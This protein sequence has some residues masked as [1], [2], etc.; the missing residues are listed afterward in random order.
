MAFDGIAARCIVWELSGLIRGGK[1]LK[2]FQPEEDEI[3]L[4]IRRNTANYRLLISAN[5]QN[6]RIGIT[7]ISKE[8]PMTAPNFCMALRKHLQG[9]VI[10]DI[11]QKDCDRI[12]TITFDTFNEMGDPVVKKLVAEI[13]GRYSNIILL[14]GGDTIIDSIRHVDSRLS[15]YREV[16]PA[17]PY[18]PPPPQDKILPWDSGA[19]EKVLAALGDDAFRDRNVG[20]LLADTISGFSKPLCVSVC[21]RAGVPYDQKAGETAGSPQTAE[22]LCAALSEVFERISE[23]RYSPGII[24]EGEGAPADFHPLTEFFAE[25]SKRYNTLS[26][27]MD[28]FFRE[29]D[30]A[31]HRKNVS[32]GLLKVINGAIDKNA[33]KLAALRLDVENAADFD[34]QKLFGDIL[35]GNLYR[36]SGGEKEIVCDDYSSGCPVKVTIPLDP[37]QSPGKNLQ[38]YYK[39]YK[40][41]KSK[42]E[43]A[44]VHIE[45]TERELA[46]L[47]SVRFSLENCVSMEDIAQI[48]NE[49]QGGGYVK[50]VSEKMKKRP[51]AVRSE[52]YD[53]CATSDGF[54]VWIGKNNVQNELITT[55]KAHFNDVWFHVKQGPGAH[56]ILRASEQDGRI[57]EKAIFEAARICARRSGAGSGDSREVDYTRVKHVK[58]QSGGKPGMVTYT[59]YKTIVVKL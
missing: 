55:R 22:R 21:E 48:R 56:V 46:Y 30:L 1:V 54:T 11:T 9:A 50:N 23:N 43:N 49:L 6:A 58:K 10:S 29:R 14:T 42:S 20:K 3:S 31:Q 2:V 34:K 45:E 51:P 17:R 57:T 4:Q 33:K 16:L 18:A 27:C 15:S 37:H 39:S 28:D 8:N 44:L 12:V 32:G 47:A 5:S 40:K 59:N 52:G 19:A 26:G 36:L 7:G 35:S 25:S 13:M 38:N 24:L 53:V 41:K